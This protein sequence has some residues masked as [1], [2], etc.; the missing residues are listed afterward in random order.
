MFPTLIRLG[1][2]R[3]ATYG[4]LVASG[5]L[6]G[7]W[8]LTRRRERMGLT[9]DDF[10]SLVYALFFGA[11]L[12]GKLLYL[13]VEWRSLLDGSLRPLRDIRYGF[14]FFGGVTGSM[15]G[16]WL[17]CRWKGRSFAKYADY[18]AVALPMGHAL[19]RVGCLSA[20]CCYGRPTS[21]PW[22]VTFTNPEALVSPAL[23]GVPLH[24]VQLY[25]SA[26]DLLIVGLCLRVLARVETGAARPGSGWAVYFLGYSVARFLLEFLRGDDRGQGLLGLSPSQAIAIVVAATA[27]SWLWRA[28][29]A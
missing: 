23:V 19:G 1:S 17:W 29:T 26:A 28:R 22:G 12:G 21:L 20:G 15:A 25:E 27:S 4:V 24:P 11:L 2:F 5:Y 18:F 3:L 10:W 16:G 13:G 9:E 6:L 14:V 8:W 7:I